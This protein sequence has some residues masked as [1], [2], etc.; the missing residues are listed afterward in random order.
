MAN[1]RVERFS[2][3]YYQATMKKGRVSTPQ[4]FKAPTV[5]A[6]VYYVLRMADGTCLGP[7]RN[8]NGHVGT[9]EA[10]QESLKHT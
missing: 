6:K 7:S 9:L 3:P 2:D 8:C 10:L 1:W 5:L 4:S